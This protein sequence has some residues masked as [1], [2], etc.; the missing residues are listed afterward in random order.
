MASRRRP[1]RVALLVETT[2]TYTR[3]LLAGVRRYVAAHGPWSCFI[4][5]RALESGPPP[6]L[7]NWDGDGI[8]TRTFTQEMADVIAATGLPAVEL[9]ATY[10]RSE[11]PF[12]GMNSGLIGQMVAEHFFDRGYRNFATYSLHTERF[13]EERVQNYIAA[14]EGRGGVCSLLPEP[15]SDRAADWEKGQARLMEWLAGLPKPVGI[16]AANDQ[17]GVRLLDACQRAG[18]AVPEEV[19]VVGAE[20]EETLCAFANPPLTS[21]R[22]DGATVGFAAAELLARLM[23]G[24]APP[25]G[26]TLFPPKGIVVRESSDEFVI[27]DRLVAHAA[28]M[29]RENAAAGLNVDDLCRKL[30]ASR[31]TLDRR[32]R[33]AIGRTP[34]EEILRVRFREVQRLLRETDLTIEAIAGLTGFAHSHYLQAAFK[35]AYGQT[36]GEFRGKKIA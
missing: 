6:W 27:N 25:K 2:R 23:R 22:F 15:I 14:V 33:T 21:V 5:L 10:L 24:G 1:P 9:R 19:A 7:R 26:G 35:H 3:E 34:K 17:L 13:F 36:P 29:I 4:E 16:F 12:V 30:N 32:M 28:R 31:S 11:L 20:N 18:I 8:I